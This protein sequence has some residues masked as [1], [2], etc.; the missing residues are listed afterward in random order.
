MARFIMRGEGA[1]VGACVVSETRL[2]PCPL[3]TCQSPQAP[4]FRNE[5]IFT[6]KAHR[7]K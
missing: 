6:K 4:S 5:V 7:T 3:T 2:M 1:M